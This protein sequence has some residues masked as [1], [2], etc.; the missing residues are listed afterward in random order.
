MYLIDETGYF[1]SIKVRLEHTCHPHNRQ[2]ALFQFH[3][4]TI[5]TQVMNDEGT[6]VDNFNSIKVRLEPTSPS[7]RN[8]RRLISIP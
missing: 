6:D 7:C 2:I 8:S 1:N 4:G 3:K 5:R